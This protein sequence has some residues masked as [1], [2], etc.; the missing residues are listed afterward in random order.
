[1]P[2]STTFL[3][4][5]QAIN[6]RLQR[7]MV[8]NLAAQWLGWVIKRGV[9]FVHHMGNVHVLVGGLNVPD[10]QGLWGCWERMF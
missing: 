4:A 8:P 7:R 5:S 2:T 3:L 6:E 9:K 1:M 10:F